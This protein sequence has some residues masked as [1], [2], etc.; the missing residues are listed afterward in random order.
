M[1]L[2]YN[3]K[4][5]RFYRW[6]YE[7]DTMPEMLREY[8]WKIVLALVFCIP[9]W[10]LILPTLLV[11]PSKKEGRLI[12]IV[13]IWLL[14]ATLCAIGFSSS[15]LWTKIDPSSLL[16]AFHRFGLLVVKICLI[17]I[18]TGSLLILFIVVENFKEIEKYVVSRIT[19]VNSRINWKK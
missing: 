6:F 19:K 13:Y 14:I 1:Q 15:S 4:L 12:N 10:M 5:A 16:G 8:I 2:D 3:S 9:Y 17:I 18:V 11:K 7:K